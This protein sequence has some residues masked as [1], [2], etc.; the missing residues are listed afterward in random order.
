MLWSEVLL[1]AEREGKGMCTEM[2]EQYRKYSWSNKLIQAF[3]FLPVEKSPCKFNPMHDT[4]ECILDPVMFSI[5]ICTNTKFKKSIHNVVW[6]GKQ[7][8]FLI[9]EMKYIKPKY[10]GKDDQVTLSYTS[11]VSTLHDL[12]YSTSST[13]DTIH[14]FEKCWDCSHFLLTIN[15]F[16]ILV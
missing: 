10:N 5:Y 13:K 11:M 3:Q 7:N 1:K 14:I 9:L 8:Y 4:V 15:N 2:T 12:F 6:L 16:G